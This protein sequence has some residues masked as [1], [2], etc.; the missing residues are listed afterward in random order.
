[1]HSKGQDVSVDT[2][3]ASSMHHVPYPP[4]AYDR[5]NNDCTCIED[6]GL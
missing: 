1:M 6:C 5:T 4:G 2:V 3:V